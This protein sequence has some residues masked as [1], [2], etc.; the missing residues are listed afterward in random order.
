MTKK[1]GQNKKSFEDEIKNNKT[2]KTFFFLEG[3]S[4]TLTASWNPFLNL[5]P[6]RRAVNNLMPFKC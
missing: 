4:P 5:W 2:N 1:S 6:E 3:E